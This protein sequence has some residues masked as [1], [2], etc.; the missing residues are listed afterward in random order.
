MASNAFV[1]PNCRTWFEGKGDHP[2]CPSCGRNYDP[3][4]RKEPTRYAST[5]GTKKGPALSDPSSRSTSNRLDAL[6]S[7]AYVDSPAGRHLTLS[8]LLLFFLRSFFWIGFIVVLIGLFKP[9]GLLL[10]AGLFAIIAPMVLESRLD[11]D[12]SRLTGAKWFGK[13]WRR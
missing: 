4:Q 3:A 12:S 13:G 2:R 9:N 8:S 5:F 11:K 6:Q 7:P 1:C 10:I